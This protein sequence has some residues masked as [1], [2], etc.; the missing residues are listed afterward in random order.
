MGILQILKKTVLVYKNNFGK[1]YLPLLAF[2]LVVLLPMLF[3]TMP[4]TVNAARALLKTLTMISKTGSGI[5][6]VFYVIA[7]MLLA[8]LFVSPLVVSNTVYI[9]DKDYQC[10]TVT[11][12]ESFRFSRSNYKQMLS[13]YF[14]GIAGLIPVAAVVLLLLF[15]V[16]QVDFYA[17][18]PGDIV[19]IVAC[20]IL[21]LLYILGTAFVPYAVVSEDKKGFGALGASFRY[22]YKGNFWSNLSRLAVAVLIIGALMMLINWLAQLPFAELFDL[23]LVDPAAALQEPLMALAIVLALAAIFLVSLIMPFWYAF[24]FNAYKSALAEYQKKIETNR[25]EV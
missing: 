24:S 17:L 6:S 12:R 20:V 3:F 5:T 13:S 7:F 2:Q 18:S 14:A 15:P 22:I 25:K 19:L 23:Y 9:V 16:A 4:G 8:L 21:L 10:K 1:M 11:F